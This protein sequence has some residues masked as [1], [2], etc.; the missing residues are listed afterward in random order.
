MNAA[1]TRPRFRTDLVAQ[2]LEEGGHRYVDVTD[3]DSGQTYRFYE[4]EY[5]IACAMDGRRDLSG[6][7]DW[8]HEE[9]GLDPTSGE[10]TTVINTLA[11]LGY[12]VD[13]DQ[14]SSDAG[15]AF[16]GGDLALGHAGVIDDSDEPEMLAEGDDFELGHAG[17]ESNDGP[18][19]E[20]GV[21][22]PELALGDAGATDEEPRRPSEDGEQ[23]FAGLLDDEPTRVKAGVQAAPEREPEPL[24]LPPVPKE[25]IAQAPEPVRPVSVIE[26]DDDEEE[27]E[28][29]DTQLP[30]P[31]SDFDDEVSVDLTDHIKLGPDAVKEAVRQSRM[32][33]AAQPI[34]EV[35][36][37]PSSPSNMLASLRKDEPPFVELPEKRVSVSMPIEPPAER[38]DEV[39]TREPE[40][41]SRAGLLV[42][43]LLL[44]IAGLAAV[45]MFTGILG[46]KEMLGLGTTQE[47]ATPEPAPDKPDQPVGEQPA[48]KQPERPVAPLEAAEAAA[49]EVAP[50]K[51]GKLASIVASGTAVEAEQVV[52]VLAGAERIEKEIA[53]LEERRDYY[54]KKQESAAPDSDAAKSAERKVQEKEAGAEE[55]RKELQSLQLKAPSAGTV[56]TT[57]K[58]G[59]SVEPGKPA[60]SITQPAQLKATFTVPAEISMDSYKVDTE[61]ELVA[62]DDNSKT[63]GCSVTAVDGN[64]VTVLCPRDGALAEGA[65]V[66]LR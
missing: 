21:D 29:G 52:A 41:K 34:A 31:S 20:M 66:V 14:D 26:I 49:V 28:D 35:S 30:G 33:S 51:A 60:F 16:S 1:Q 10:L 57:L 55:K 43:L 7:A 15:L 44:V 45:E 2:P 59:D 53:N 27:E 5:S 61:V 38:S 19:G 56:E 63:L 64:K 37:P 18:D 11:E 36:P 39:I 48:P 65:E 42:L 50:E 23:S 32:M 58:A 54:K 17:N 25:P 12:L 8:A 9:L 24:T 46:L 6:L 40:K 4:V 47:V 13:P 22:A 3:P 62:K